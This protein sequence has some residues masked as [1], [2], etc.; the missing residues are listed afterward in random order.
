MRNTLTSP[1]A[2]LATKTMRAIVRQQF[3][4]ELKKSLLNGD[5][6]TLR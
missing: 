3:G 4:S 6:N 2:D 1:P 5:H